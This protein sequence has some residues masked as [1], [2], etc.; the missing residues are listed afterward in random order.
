[1]TT[2]VPVRP[3][4]AS[5]TR[6]IPKSATTARR[7][8]SRMLAGFSVPVDD[9]GSVRVRESVGDLGA[10]AR[11]LPPGQPAACLDLGTKGPALDELHHDPG[12]PVAL[13]HVMDSDDTW[14]AEPGRRA[15]LPLRPGDALGP[16]VRRDLR[17]EQD[18]LDRDHPVQDLIETP[19]HPP[20]AALPD[21][22]AEQV[23]A[24]YQHPSLARHDN[25]SRR[26]GPR[27]GP[28]DCKSGLV[29]STNALVH[30]VP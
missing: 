2:P 16:L 10:D 12:D 24:T 14:V 7:P 15:G 20:E 29:N 26:A 22:L 11:G 23:P 6:A 30:D 1:M 21:R 5:R 17:P 27:P 28:P 25:D 8:D 13:H 18:L 19:P 3:A 9:P 4:V